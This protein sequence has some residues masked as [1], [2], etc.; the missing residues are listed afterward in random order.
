MELHSHS[1][2]LTVIFRSV[3]SQL[4]KSTLETGR[5]WSLKESFRFFWEEEDAVGGPASC[6]RWYA[7]AIRSRLEPVPRLISAGVPAETPKTVMRHKNFASTELH[8]GAFRSAQSAAAEITE[9]LSEA[10]FTPFVRGLAEGIEG[11]PQLT[12]E[13]RVTGLEPAAF[14]LGS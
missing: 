10:G 5:A 8:Y 7:W 6:D 9:K 12:T 3:R 2:N 14:S 11:P 13:E 1:S 4:L